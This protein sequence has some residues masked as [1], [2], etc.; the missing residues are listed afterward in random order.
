MANKYFPLRIDSGL[1]MLE[2]LKAAML[3]KYGDDFVI[4]CDAPRAGSS[5]LYDFIF[6]CP[7]ISDKAVQIT[8]E[9]Y[10]SVEWSILGDYGNA[11]S[12]DSTS[13]TDYTAFWWVTTVYG[14]GG[15]D[16]L[17]LCLGDTF[18]LF[19]EHHTKSVGLCLIAKTIGGTSI[20]YTGTNTDTYGANNL[21]NAKTVN[22]ST[23]ERIAFAENVRTIYSAPGLPYKST[24]L[25]YYDSS[26]RTDQLM[27]TA[28]GTPDTIADL[29]MAFYTDAAPLVTNTGMYTPRN[30]WSN[31]STATTILH[32]P[33]VA[34][35]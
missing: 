12:G 11:V 23:G 14:T 8:I 7:P 6:T 18:A 22:A 20:F 16:K 29:Y 21:P 32:S 34:E 3:D 9:N 2:S 19:V 28:D 24:L 33:I 17:Y 1:A 15:W 25:M 13:M 27:R 31:G 35:F 4:H 5:K 10:N 30:L 26:T